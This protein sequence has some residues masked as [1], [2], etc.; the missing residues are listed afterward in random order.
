MTPWQGGGGERWPLELSRW[1]TSVGAMATALMRRWFGGAGL[2]DG[3]ESHTK[4]HG[5]QLFKYHLVFIT[6]TYTRVLAACLQLHSHC[7]TTSSVLPCFH[8][9]PAIETFPVMRQARAQSAQSWPGGSWETH[10]GHRW[11]NH[12]VLW[13][14]GG[15]EVSRL[16]PQFMTLKRP[17]L[18]HCEHQRGLCMTQD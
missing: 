11:L 12:R 1:R 15:Y 10:F 17:H 8:E 9:P 13:L 7:S 4:W 5:D 2:A 6:Q 3:R 14:L 16:P 18:L